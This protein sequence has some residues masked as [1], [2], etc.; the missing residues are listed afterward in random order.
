MEKVYYVIRNINK[1]LLKIYNKKAT[2]NQKRIFMNSCII[3]IFLWYLIGGFTSFLLTLLLSII[4]EFTYCYVPS[5]KYKILGI[6]FKIPNYK[7]YFENFS[8]LTYQQQHKFNK[9]DLWFILITLYL[10]LF[11]S[12]C[13]VIL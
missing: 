5:V 4:M 2:D 12:L 9:D 10:F 13:K 7:F 8:Y 3:F 6:T 1:S 11:F